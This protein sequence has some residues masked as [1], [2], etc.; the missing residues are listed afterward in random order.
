MAGNDRWARGEPTLEPTPQRLAE[1]RRLGE[2]AV[3]PAL[4]AAGASAGAILALVLAGPSLWR[5]AIRFAG[6][7]W[8]QAASGHATPELSLRLCLAAAG[9]ALAPVLGLA[10][11]GAIAVGLSQTRGA[12]VWLQVGWPSA[13]NGRRS[14]SRQPPLLA[15]LLALGKVALVAAVSWGCLRPMI[16]SLAGLA[17]APA[18]RVAAVLGAM[19]TRVGVRIALALL[20]LGAAD[21]ALQWLAHQR[22]L[23]M[24]HDEVKRQRRE[25][26]GDERQR[27]RRRDI[28]RALA[29][30]G[31]PPAVD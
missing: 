31:A 2:L 9:W 14:R 29:D 6:E 19:L 4:T 8:M 30:A 7:Q 23:R 5:A 16:P 18:A 10:T 13:D 20:L 25:T 1:A 11:L 28:H 17:G 21:Y 22:G 12:I 27:A 24:T 3:S 26:E 15:G